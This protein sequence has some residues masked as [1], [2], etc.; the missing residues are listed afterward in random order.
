MIRCE[1]CAGEV[2]MQSP[3][4]GVCQI[5]GRTFSG[6]RLRRMR[7]ISPPEYNMVQPPDPDAPK[8]SAAPAI[9]LGAFLICLFGGLMVG[10]V[11]LSIVGMPIFPVI[12]LIAVLSGK[13]PKKK[14]DDQTLIFYQNSAKIAQE[15]ERARAEMRRAVQ[16]PMRSPRFTQGMAVGERLDTPMDYLEAFRILPLTSMP[17]RAEAGEAMDQLS[18]MITKQQGIATLLP[19]GH[20]YYQTINDAVAYFLKNTKQI[21][22]RMRY[23]DQN[24]MSRRE[25]H[26]AF[27][28][29]TLDE[30]AALLRDFE[31][32]MIELSQMDDDVQGRVPCLDV[33]TQSMRS[34]REPVPD[35]E[36]F[37]RQIN[38]HKNRSQLMQ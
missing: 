28:R 23:C 36:E 26:L 19:A 7:M 21:L 38:E 5:C 33:L 9:I 34:L 35:E 31:T 27:F 13:K 17:F 29:S 32:F 18:S 30:N 20:P 22:F 24:D 11:G 37:L 3:S 15:K 12:V 6:E 25:E 8:Q 4:V 1:Y 14:L 16:P 2:L 10:K